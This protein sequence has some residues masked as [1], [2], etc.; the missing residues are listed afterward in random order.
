MRSV[1]VGLAFVVLAVLAG[2]CAPA[3]PPPPPDTSAADNAAIAKLR[4]DYAAAW[5]AGDADK[6]GTYWTTD[7]VFYPMEQPTLRGRAAIVEFFKGQFAGVTPNDFVINS[8][9]VTLAGNVA[10]DHGTVDISMTPNAKGAAMMKLEGRFI[11]VVQKGGDGTWLLRTVIDNSPTPM[12][13][14]PPAGKGK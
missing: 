10:V 11:V 13:P 7:A 1:R 3:P 5:K 6:L 12:A 9:G 8:A 2:A 4:N 14:P